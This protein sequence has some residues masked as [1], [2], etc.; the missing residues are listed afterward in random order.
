[1]KTFEFKYYQPRPGEVDRRGRPAFD[2]QT[3][4]FQAE[5][6]LAAVKYRDDFL[7]DRRLEG[8]GALCEVGMKPVKKPD[9][10]E[11][12]SFSDPFR[13]RRGLR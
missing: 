13:V 10:W 11:K 6:G 4:Q 12:D 1:M 7:K 2:V 9:N 3:E 5:S 8:H